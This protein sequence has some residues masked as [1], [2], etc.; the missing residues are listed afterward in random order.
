MPI[1][2][3]D[4]PPG[5]ALLVYD[6]SGYVF[7]YPEDGLFAAF[8]NPDGSDIVRLLIPYDSRFIPFDIRRTPEANITAPQAARAF[9]AE[10]DTAFINDNV[11][12]F[13]IALAGRDGWRTRRRFVDGAFAPLVL[14]AVFMQDDATLYK[15]H[16]AARPDEYATRRWIFDPVVGRTPVP[17]FGNSQLC[18]LIR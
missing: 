4:P 16:V 7:A 11:P 9:Y 14:D 10:R 2:F 1:P 3:A 5:V 13:E 15:L 6:D 8:D 12:P 18:Q 17:T